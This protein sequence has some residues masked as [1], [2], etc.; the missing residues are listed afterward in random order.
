ML[1]LRSS[2]GYQNMFALNVFQNQFGSTINAPNQTSNTQYLRTSGLNQ[3]GGNL[4]WYINFIDQNT[5][6]EHWSQLGETEFGLEN[7]PRSKQFYLYLDGAKDNFGELLEFH[8]DMTSNGLYDY[9][10]YWG[11]ASTATSPDDNRISA[12]VHSG[13]AL[14]YNNNFVNNHYQNS[15][16]GVE[17]LTIPT[18][19]SYNG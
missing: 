19:I 6:K 8:I 16:Y 5:Q 2:N 7:F 1:H 3:S 9:N 17:Q 13:V 18:T 12:M 14:V 4:F 11:R 10:V 15:T